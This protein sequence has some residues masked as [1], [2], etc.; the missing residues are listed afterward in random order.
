[1]ATEH[2]IPRPQLVHE[3]VEEYIWQL[4][5]LIQSTNAPTSRPTP[6]LMNLWVYAPTFARYSTRVSVRNNYLE[7]FNDSL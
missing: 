7:N 6:H 5:C 2:D 3:H 1:M 4:M